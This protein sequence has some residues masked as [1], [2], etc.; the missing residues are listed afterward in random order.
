MENKSYDLQYRN[1]Q[2]NRSRMPMSYSNAG[3]T[4]L[5]GPR[6]LTKASA[7][8]QSNAIGSEK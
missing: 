5:P 1:M 4:N 2:A 6:Q 3:I 8:G 7:D